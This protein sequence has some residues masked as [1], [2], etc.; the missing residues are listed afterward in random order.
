MWSMNI[1]EAIKTY[2]VLSIFKE[3]TYQLFGIALS[4]I[5]FIVLIGYV[6]Q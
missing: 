2:T 1:G 6:E 5:F 3:K 4:S